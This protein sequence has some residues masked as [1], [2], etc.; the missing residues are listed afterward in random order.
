M[1]LYAASPES[2]WSSRSF[3]R[4]M[5]CSAVAHSAALVLVAYGPIFRFRSDI[6]MPV[7]V[8]LVEM[9]SEPVAEV[10]P[11]E[12]APPEPPPPEPPKPEVKPP[13]PEQPKQVV[14]EAL[15]VPDVP[16][17][18]PRPPKKKPAPKP[19]DVADVMQAL[20]QE[21]DKNK[22][23][24]RKSSAAGT[25]DPEM[26]AYLV[27]VKGC[28]RQNWVGAQRFQRRRDLLAQ[29]EVELAPG[30][31]VASAELTRPSGEDIFDETAERAIMKC[32]PWPE[33]PG[34]Q[35]SIPI[36]FAP[37]EMQ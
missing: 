22:P 13:E 26:A 4:F 14:E 34:G 5:A 37:E 32:Q 17:E 1:N 36:T 31:K 25:L 12:P 18:K 21:A 24:P 28:L 27:R 33:P 23:P 2:L 16:P 10:S 30:G 19:P 29:F 15:V 8:S 6:P 11:P 35:T 9:P 20:R 7:P 3:V